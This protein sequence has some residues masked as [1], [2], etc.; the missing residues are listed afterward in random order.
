MPDITLINPAFDTT[1]KE[2][3]VRPI[4]QARPMNVLPMQLL[5]IAG[6]LESKGYNVE[7]LDT[8]LYSE[9]DAMKKVLEI[10]SP[11]VGL[12]AMTE[13]IKSSL[14]ITDAI[15]EQDKKIK[16]IW[17]GMHPTLYGKQTTEEPNIDFI[18]S[19]EGEIP[20]LNILKG[21]A[22]HFQDNSNKYLDANELT[23]PAFHLIDVEPYMDR[24]LYNGKLVRWMMLLTSRGCPYRCSFCPDPIVYKSTWHPMDTKKYIEQIDFVVEKYK[25]QHIYPYDEL[26]FVDVK[27]LVPIFENFR[28]HNLSWEANCR[29]DMITRFPDNFMQLIKDSGCAMLRM[30][31]ESGSNRMLDVVIKKDLKKEQTIEAIARCTKYGIQVMAAYI[32]GMPQETKEDII[33]TIRMIYELQRIAPS[34][35]HS[36]PQPFRPYAGGEMYK[37]VEEMGDLK[38]P[39]SLRE[40][41]DFEAS[42]GELEGFWIQDKKFVEDAIVILS[43][44]Q[45]YRAVYPTLGDKLFSS[46]FRKFVDAR[47]K[48]NY[49]NNMIDIK[50]AKTILKIKRKIAGS[51]KY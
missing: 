36:G 33:Q 37:M 1:R 13:S 6:Y 7:V 18:I 21:D 43:L 40:W 49:W 48:H 31:I 23:L 19:G 38:E 28:E 29:A 45:S 4:T 10:N 17:G 50:T 46:L 44:I 26:L 14:K 32:I 12:G 35:V 27:R 39:K 42:Y 25:I 30:G 51:P 20:I 2:P 11:F 34:L 8:R 15:K 9:E 47:Y 24:I 5:Y 3:E 41:A 16:V 22:P